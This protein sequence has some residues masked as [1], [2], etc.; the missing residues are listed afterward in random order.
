MVGESGS[1]PA[2]AVDQWAAAMRELWNDREAR[3]A[4]GA[5]ALERARERFSSN[6]FYSGL[7]EIYARAGAG[8]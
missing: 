2:R 1:I 3:R 5:A 6:R 7:M 4:R 8:G